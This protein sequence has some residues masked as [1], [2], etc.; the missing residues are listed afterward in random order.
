MRVA[1]GR[2]VTVAAL[3][4]LSAAPG[5]VPAAAAPCSSQWQV[6]PS[7]NPGNSGNVLSGVFA[8][9]STDVWAVGHSVVTTTVA[10]MPSTVTDTLIEHYDGTSW[11]AV[12]G[13]NTGGN[14]LLP[15]TAGSLDAVW[16][17][18]PT[19]V[20]AVGRAGL[21]EHW[22][23]STWSAVSAAAN[24]QDLLGV[25]GSGPSDV[26]AVGSQTSGNATTGVTER[27]DGSSWSV[28]PGAD[29]GAGAWAAVWGT[30][31]GDV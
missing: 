25:W 4:T 15:S 26:W 12:Q 27:W 7:A 19:D 13:A 17:S 10:G 2:I 28:V 23:G 14:P 29:S 1:F 11:S 16:G 9:G 5:A 30:G 6:V 24:T 22:N 20:W 31:P 3:L 18:G 8:V 21:I